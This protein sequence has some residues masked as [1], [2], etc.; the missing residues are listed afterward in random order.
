MQAPSLQLEYRNSPYLLITVSYFLRRKTKK[1]TPNLHFPT[2][3]HPHKK[4]ANIMF[5]GEG[6]LC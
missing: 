5:A 1:P 4:E 3:T 6:G 2:P